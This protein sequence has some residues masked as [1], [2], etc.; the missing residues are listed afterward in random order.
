MQ[1]SHAN[2]ILINNYQ[3]VCNLVSNSLIFVKDKVLPVS[4]YT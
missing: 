1:F 4:W 3:D 2:I